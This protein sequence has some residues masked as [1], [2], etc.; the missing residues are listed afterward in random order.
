M[1]FRNR[2]G[3]RSTTVQVWVG[4]AGERRADGPPGGRITYYEFEDPS[5]PHSQSIF[6]RQSVGHRMLKSVHRNTVVH[7]SVPRFMCI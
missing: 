5:H 4:R 2:E 6:I 3:C 1:T 7:I